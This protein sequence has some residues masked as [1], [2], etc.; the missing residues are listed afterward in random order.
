MQEHPTLT[1]KEVFC[2]YWILICSMQI[3]WLTSFECQIENII[4][5]LIRNVLEF[6]SFATIKFVDSDKSISD[7]IRVVDKNRRRLI[8]SL[9]SSL[10]PQHSPCQHHR[11]GSELSIMDIARTFF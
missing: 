11:V 7:A 8:N 1:E 6:L 5:V 9:F 10:P 4:K 3:S 2:R